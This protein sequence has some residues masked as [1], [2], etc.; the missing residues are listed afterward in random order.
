MSN[1][2]QECRLGLASTAIRNDP[3]M[4]IRRAA[5]IYEVP[6]STVRRRMAGKTSK[7]DTHHGQLNLTA[8]EEEAIIRYVIDLDSRGFSPRRCDVRDM[9]DLLMAKRGARHVGKCWTDRFIK[10]QPK[11]RTRFSRAYDYQRALQEDP[12]VLDAWFRLVANMRAKYVIQ[13]CDFYNFDETGF[14]M[15][16]IRTGTVVTRSDRV[17]K[18]KAIQPGNREWTTAICCIAAD[19]HI[20]PPFLCVA[21]RFHLAAWYSGGHVKTNWV[22]KPTQ[23]GWTDHDTGLEWLRHFDQHT[24]V[25]QKGR[26]RMLVLDGH[27]SHVNA[28]FDEYCKAN[29]IVPIC[30]PPHSSHL[31]QPLDVGVFGPLKKTY[32]DQISILARANITHIT[33]DDFFPAFRAAFEADFTEQNV[34]GGFRGAG[35]VPFNSDAVISKLDIRLRT[36]TPETSDGLPQPWVSQTPKTATE[37]ISQSTLIKD[38]VTKHQGSSPTS[39]LNSVDQLTKAAVAVG[40]QS[41]LLSSEIKVLREANE[42]LSKRRRAKRTRLQDSGPLTGEEASQLLVEKGAVTQEGRDEGAGEGSSKRRK[43]SARHCGNCRKAGHNAR[44]CTEAAAVDCPSDPEQKYFI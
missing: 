32:G 27:E 43:T 5:K 38:R 18:P 25:R 42:A 22:V 34:K 8:A 6:E 21:G 26:Y 41:T 13:D 17:G 10:R 11:L 15:G 19:G 35:L 20:V 36:P 14:A 31:T 33:K 37:V 39:I 24:R 1:H 12:H 29:S 44:T 28:E 9:A 4:S 30:L 16:M 7:A 40:H 2:S 23:N 3:R